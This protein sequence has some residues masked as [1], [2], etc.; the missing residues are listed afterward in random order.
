MMLQNP[1][2]LARWSLGIALAFG[3]G[4]GSDDSGS[5]GGHAG[6]AGGGNGGSAVGGGGGT[7]SGGTNSGGTSSGGTNS[8][9]TSSG[10]TNSGGSAGS[11]GGTSGA[12]EVIATFADGLSPINV[13]HVSPTGND[14]ND[15]SETK[16]KK[17]I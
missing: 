16:P 7:S 10:G 6:K 9:G 3:S 2:R 15:G 17:T 4:C 5:S 14:A 12:C 8:G 13:L 11:A 1:A